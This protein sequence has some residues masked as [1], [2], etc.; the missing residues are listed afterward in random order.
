LETWRWRELLQSRH[1]HLETHLHQQQATRTTIE[2]LGRSAAEEA[3]VMMLPLLPLLLEKQ[4][5]PLPHR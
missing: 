1:F 2:L 4:V 5:L 3:G